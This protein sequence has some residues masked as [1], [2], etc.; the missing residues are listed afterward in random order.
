VPGRLVLVCGLPGAGK[1]TTALQLVAEEGGVR[2]SP[3]EWMHELGIDIWD[4]QARARIEALQW[5]VGQE[6]LTAGVT[7]VIEWG[8]WTRAERDRLRERARELGVPVELRFL[9]ETLEVLW[10]RVRTR[11]REQEWGWRAIERAELAE[12]ADAFEAPDAEEQARFDR[13][14]DESAAPRPSKDP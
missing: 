8:L 4:Q 14:S 2:F 7:V 10:E 9:D 6:L 12:W 3:D 11:G 13:P 1:T 5:Q